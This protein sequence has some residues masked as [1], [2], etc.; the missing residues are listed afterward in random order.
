MSN[1]NKLFPYEAPSKKVTAK[2]CDINGHRKTSTLGEL[3]PDS[4]SSENL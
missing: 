4:F 2:M 1:L 3:L